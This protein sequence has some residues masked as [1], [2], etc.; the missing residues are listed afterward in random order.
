MNPIRILE[1]EHE[2]IERELLEFETI[3]DTEV[4]N[5]PNLLHVFRRFC[6][7]WDEHELKEVQVFRIMN[8][9]HI[10]IPIREL[11]CEHTELRV[12]IDGLKN[13]LNSGN[14]YL[15]HKSFDSD[16]RVLISKVR[17]HMGVEDE[18]LYTVSAKEFSE[19]ELNKMRD[20]LSNFTD[21]SIS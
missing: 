7:I 16:L 20:A 21:A 14:D 3:M 2:D 17:N 10:T 9:G 12:H 6:K 4:I 18:I 15:L 11:T 8:R 5:Y 13:A 1:I 19:T